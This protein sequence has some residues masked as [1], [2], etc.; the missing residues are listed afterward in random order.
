LPVEDGCKGRSHVDG[1]ADRD[2]QLADRPVVEALDFDVGLVGVDDR[3]KVAAV[4]VVTGLHEPLE[5][6][7]FVHIGTE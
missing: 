7:A 3:D 2:E 5:D 4:H 6:R 1:F